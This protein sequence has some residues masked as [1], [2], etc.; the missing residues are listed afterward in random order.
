MIFLRAIAPFFALSFPSYCFLTSLCYYYNFF[1]NPFQSIP[2]D[3]HPITFLYIMFRLHILWLLSL[4][5]LVSDASAA[6]T[7]YAVIAFP[8]ATQGVAVTVNGQSYKLQRSNVHPNL[9]TGYAPSGTDYQYVIVDSKGA[10]VQSE[11]SMRKAE[12]SSSSVGNE[13][14]DRIPTLHQ[15][16]EIPQAFNPINPRKSKSKCCQCLKTAALIISYANIST[17]AL[18]TRMNQSNEIATLFVRADKDDF[19]DILT[20]PKDE[21]NDD[22]DM[23][24]MVYISHSEVHSFKGGHIGNSGHTSKNFNRQS[25]QIRLKKD[26]RL[27]GRRT[28]K[29]RAEQTDPSFM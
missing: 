20:D 4:L 19:T 21:E 14:F 13:F 17:L 3:F 16:P 1:F 22:A 26:Q 11:S 28:F 29:L 23:L 25:L 9:Y 27:F 6:D 2:L 8:N 15:V 24:D 12:A 10:V 5:L 18:F 7:K